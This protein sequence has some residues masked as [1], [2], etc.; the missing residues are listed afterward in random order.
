[1]G[2]ASSTSTS[3]KPAAGARPMS[4]HS[5]ILSTWPPLIA[6]DAATASDPGPL[7]SPRSLTQP[8]GRAD[9]RA[10]RL[11]PTP[12][13]VPRT[14]H[15]IRASAH[16]IPRARASTRP[17]T[18]PRWTACVSSLTAHCPLLQH[19]ELYDSN[20]P[21]TIRLALQ[22][23]S[24]CCCRLL[25][26]GQCPRPMQPCR[27]SPW[28]RVTS[29]KPAG[30]CVLQAA[31]E[32]KINAAEGCQLPNIFLLLLQAAAAPQGQAAEAYSAPAHPASLPSVSC[33]PYFPKRYPIPPSS[34]HRRAQHG[35]AS[36]PRRRRRRRPPPPT[37]PPTRTACAGTLRRSQQCCP[38]PCLRRRRPGPRR[39]P[40]PLPRASSQPLPS[41]TTWQ[42]TQARPTAPAAGKPGAAPSRG[43]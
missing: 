39:A 42:P 19:T 15:T 30:S 8:A 38:L 25:L 12:R 10:C 41:S 36:H 33:T 37:H 21:P 26:L 17:P 6:R 32:A 20:D 18:C 31:A 4:G 29:S 9:Q 1:M 40:A 16:D 7:I 5:P 28:M 43:T 13:E 14:R 24:C 2:Q 34:P 11:T 27:S 22:L 35:P 3:T 23:G